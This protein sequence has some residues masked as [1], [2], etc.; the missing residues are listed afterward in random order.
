MSTGGLVA[1]DQQLRFLGHHKRVLMI[2]A[3]PDDEDTEL[4]TVLARGM[5]AEVAYLALT[6][7]EGGQNLIGPELG[8]A[9]GVLRTEELLAARELDGARQYFTRA[10]DFGYSK[11]LPDTWR[12]WPADSVLKDVVRVVRRFQPQVIVAVFSGTPRDGHGQH[13]ASGWAARQA[14][15]AAGDPGRFPELAQ[16]EGLHPWTPLKL[17]QSARFDAG[18]ATLVL[19]G[20]VLDRVVGQSFLQIAMRGRSLHRSQ[21][22]G[23][24]QRM[25]PSE[26]RL[27]RVADRTGSPAHGLFAGLDTTLGALA[28]EGS[29]PAARRALARLGRELADLRPWSAGR[30]PAL[31][32]EARRLLGPG[33]APGSAG[34]A[35][36]LRRLDD[37][38]WTASGLMCDA[39]TGSD[40]LVP[41]RPVATVLSC[42]NPGATARTVRGS[43]RLLDREVG[44]L[45]PLTLAPGRL[46]VDTLTTVVPE[47]A[48]PTDPYF[49]RLGKQ[50]NV[51]LY[52]WPPGLGSLAGAPF[53]P[54]PLRAHFRLEEGGG[55]EREVVYRFV[56]QAIGE[57]RRPLAVVPALTVSLAPGAVLWPMTDASARTFG[58]TVRSQ[59]PDSVTAT[60]R[61]EGPPGWNL[62]GTRQVRLAGA[63]AEEV[64]R[65]PVSPPAG[66][67]P[68]RVTLSA[69]AEDG[70]GRRFRQ[71]ATVVDYPHV[72][73]RQLVQAADAEVVVA[74]VALPGGGAMGYVRGA[75]DQIPEALEALG[76]PVTLLGPDSLA[77]GA[78]DRFAVLVIGPRAYETDPVL[79]DQTA[80][81]H[82]FA[83]AGGTVIVQ[84]Q[85]QAFFR[86]G[87]VP[88]PLSLLA[89]S[90]AGEAPFR[91]TAPRV[92]EE[93]VP[94]RV[95]VPDAP[96]FHVPNR[97][98]PADWDGWVQER[99]LYFARTW[100]E[101]WQPLVEMADAGE[102]PQRG[103]LLVT[104]A[105]RGWYVYTGLSFFRQ[106]PAAVPG[107]TRLFL[108]LLALRGDAGTR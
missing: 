87:F 98:G 77:R 43:L 28:P 32:A 30:L 29:R 94:V 11:G 88:A 7:G 23:S 35:D 72:R 103:G 66:I 93:D 82:A 90:A 9:L 85:Q 15:D 71:S 39:V 75:A 37:A 17:F 96:V 76:V 91:V 45:G 79:P 6:R 47:D 53:E 1:L 64:L 22:M 105:G 100:D 106:L 107:P 34:R 68:G 49:L 5:G 8:D 24:L 10:F 59:I 44:A 20:G 26:V 70:A 19:D 4:L 16:E 14:F 57:I 31:A 95:L 48:P 13:Q 3:H 108:N 12:W 21:D 80:R 25:G 54:A 56:D 61:L 27:A 46:T 69:V 42:W 104:R 18:S 60:V 63:R 51:A 58:V 50:A 86:G 99:G 78:L 73:P 67:V 92:A 41:G 55:T 84:Y 40:R 89:A 83:R 97:I 74:P 33:D 62:G 102:P 65:F 52:Q 101:A 81:L 2:G 38:Q 36:L